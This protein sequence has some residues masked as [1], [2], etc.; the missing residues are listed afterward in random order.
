MT[1]TA[2][3]GSVLQI[4]IAFFNSIYDRDFLL[5]TTGRQGRQDDYL[6]PTIDHEPPVGKEILLP[7]WIMDDEN[8]GAIRHLRE[9]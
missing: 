4:L 6:L 7:K 9:A 3:L 1:W 8:A 5:P 2:A